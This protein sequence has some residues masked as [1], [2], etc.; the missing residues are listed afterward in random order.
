MLLAALLLA[1]APAA[2]RPQVPAAKVDML[3]VVAH[4]DDETTFGGMLPWYAT[5][6]GKRVALVCL[7]SGEWG[8]GLPHH[9][10]PDDEPD[11]SYDDSDVP[12]F[13]G[14]P[15]DATYPCYFRETELAAALAVFGVKD[16]PTLPRYQDDSDLEHWGTPDAAFELWGGREGVVDY[17]AEQV[18]RCRPDVV[19]TMAVD[20]YNGNP[21]HMA[22][23]RGTVLA[24]DRAAASD[25]DAPAWSAPKLYVAVTQGSPDGIDAVP[26]AYRAA[27]GVVHGHDWELPCDASGGETARSLCNRGNVLHASQNMQPDCP[28]ATDFV[29][30]RTTVGPDVAARNNLFENLGD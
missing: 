21:Q 6:R 24:V 7:T 14:V 17:L 22:A 1:T 9:T 13:P 23:S 12:R 8:N 19:V 18:R 10:D 27:E 5:C 20:G 15:A 2:D 29:L 25:G 4:P 26:E 11:Y 16:P 3:V 28:K 30:I